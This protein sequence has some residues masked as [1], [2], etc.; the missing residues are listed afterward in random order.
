[1]QATPRVLSDALGTFKG[2]VSRDFQPTNSLFNHILSPYARK[3]EVLQL[4]R[5]VKTGIFGKSVLSRKI[6]ETSA[7]H[8]FY[9]IVHSK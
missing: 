3:N 5:L 2:T 4:L 6:G 7:I 1:M 8:L 9:V